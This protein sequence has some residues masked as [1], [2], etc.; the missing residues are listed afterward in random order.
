MSDNR[1]KKFNFD[2]GNI[3]PMVIVLVIMLIGVLLTYVVPAGTYD[4]TV[5][6]SGITRID[7]DSYARMEQTPVNPIDL[8]AIITSAFS[9]SISMI[10]LIGAGAGAFEVITPIEF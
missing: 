4:V 8:P 6:E 10:V 1:K 9:N 7:V 3:D 2:F 5:D